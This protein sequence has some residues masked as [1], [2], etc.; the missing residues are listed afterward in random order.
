MICSWINQVCVSYRIFHYR[1]FQCVIIISRQTVCHLK[2]KV[3][4]SY[5]YHMCWL[6]FPQKNT[7]GD[8]DVYCYLLQGTHRKQYELIVISFSLILILKYWSVLIFNQFW[9]KKQPWVN[10]CRMKHDFTLQD[11]S[12]EIVIRFSDPISS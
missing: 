12:N 3:W 5:I 1:V 6:G 9:H 10:F 7:M 11:E 4:G 2:T 8:T